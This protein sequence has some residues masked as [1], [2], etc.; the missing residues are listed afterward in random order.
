MIYRKVEIIKEI[1]QSINRKDI[2]KNH[3]E[4]GNKTPSEK[5]GA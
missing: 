4:K 2:E 3:I 5:E 1:Y